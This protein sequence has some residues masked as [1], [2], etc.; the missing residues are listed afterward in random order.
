MNSQRTLQ[1]RKR[2]SHEN[3]S[4]S[5]NYMKMK[6]NK[7]YRNKRLNDS[8]EEDA[9]VNVLISVHSKLPK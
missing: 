7:T 9:L 4:I 3:K 6:I 1:E 2:I 8:Q 5:L